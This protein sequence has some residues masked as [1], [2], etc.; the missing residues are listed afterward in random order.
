M[1]KRQRTPLDQLEPRRI[2]IIKPS[3]LGDIIHALPVL[4]GLRRRF[5]GAHISWLVS[6]SYESLLAGHPDLNDTIRFSRNTRGSWWKGINDFRRLLAELRRRRFDLVLDL[7]GL[8]RSGIMAW[9][10]R[11]PHRIGLR[12]AREGASFFYTDVI[13]GTDRASGGHAVDRYWRAAA[14]L[15]ANA[16]DRVF[17]FPA[18]ESEGAWAERALSSCPRPWLTAA[19]GARWTTKRWPAAH[20]A[21]LLGRAQA[22]FGGT[23][24]FVGGGEDM[25]ASLEA[26]RSLPG[27][28]LH[29]I[30]RT[31]LPQLAALLARVDVMVA[32]DTGP[33]HLACA[34]GRP[35]VAPYTCTRADLT[36]PYGQR[37]GAVETTVWCAGSLWKTCPRMECLAELVPDRLW[38]VL[39]EVLQRWQTAR[40][41]A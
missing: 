3:A 40:R 27:P 11:A 36:G 23:V 12:G 19:V 2:C 16:A 15:G 5:P 41:S 4:T 35:V 10:T 17:R 8:L 25:P 24:L 20:F 31:T 38:P 13:E 37:A 39:R 34:L 29:L 7:Q 9:A 28:V 32:N 30:G 14:A 1:L 26:A 22:A 6:R 18:F 33:L 21:D